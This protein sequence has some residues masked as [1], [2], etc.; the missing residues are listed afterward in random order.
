MKIGLDSKHWINKASYTDLLPHVS[1]RIT[2]PV[3]LTSIF[4]SMYF[5][6]STIPLRID[7]VIIH[8][9]DCNGVLS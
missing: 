3:A 2:P 1:I 5:N 8:H 4:S 6:I 9:K 7:E